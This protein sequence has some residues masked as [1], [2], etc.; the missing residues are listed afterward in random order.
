LGRKRIL[1][2]AH[3]SLLLFLFM[4]LGDLFVKGIDNRVLLPGMAD[5]PNERE[6]AI[7]L[8]I[9]GF[10][11]GEAGE[12][13]DSTPAGGARIGLVASRQSLCCET[14]NQLR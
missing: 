4:Q 5:E 8:S 14:S 9:F 7:R 1:L 2:P 12:P 10:A 3:L 13:A 11:I 6:E